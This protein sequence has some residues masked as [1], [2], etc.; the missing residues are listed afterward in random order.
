[1][2]DICYSVLIQI[3]TLNGML[4]LMNDLFCKSMP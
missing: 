3:G 4:K 2:P 1:M